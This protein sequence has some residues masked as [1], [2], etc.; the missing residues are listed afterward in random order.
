MN[1]SAANNPL[2]QLRDIHLPAPVSWW[3]LAPGWYILIVLALLLGTWLLWRIHKRK[4]QQRFQHAILAEFDRYWQQQPPAFAQI[5]ILLKRAAFIH[6]P[7]A[8]IAGL[9]SEAW[10]NWLDEQT[11][12]QAYSQGE[13]RIL[14]TG[15]Y[16]RQAIC[17]HDTA[18]LFK[19]TLVILLNPSQNHQKEKKIC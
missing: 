11:R 7:R 8:M 1:P 13:G 10:L 17:H 5:N 16:Q 6:H 4:Q 3:P 2:S 15:P 19:Q 18:L 9:S 12:T 14:L